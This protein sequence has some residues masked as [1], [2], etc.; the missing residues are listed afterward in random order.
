MVPSVVECRTMAGPERYDAFSLMKQFRPDEATLGDALSL[1]V[2]RPDYGFIWLAYAD[3]IPVG[4]ISVAFGIS[5]A[6]GGVLAVLRDL[7]VDPTYR[8]KGVGTAMLL[9]L[10]ARLDQLDVRETEVAAE[11]EPGLRA[12]LTARGYAARSGTVFSRRR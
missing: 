9:T 10:Q 3:G 7:W 2:D 4:C 8:R 11:D 6:S 12:L 5:T 1:F